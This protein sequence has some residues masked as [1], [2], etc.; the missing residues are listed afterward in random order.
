MHAPNKMP[1]SHHAEPLKNPG[2]PGSFRFRHA[3][4]VLCWFAA[5]A[6]AATADSEEAPWHE[7]AVELPAFPGDDNLLPFFVSATSENRFLIDSKSIS[8][9]S[10]DVVRYTLVIATPSG[11]RNTSYEG[12]RC[13]TAERRVYA[14]GRADGTWSK[15][16]GDQWVR[17][18]ENSLNRHHAE[19]FKVYFCPVG[20]VLRDADDA[21]RSLRNGGYPAAR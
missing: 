13:A 11:A 10:D 15:A 4:C 17:I 19:L 12:I 9:G 16:R 1:A 7:I 20:I 5:N 18:S 21:R 6:L 2:W 3:I 14:F 8:V